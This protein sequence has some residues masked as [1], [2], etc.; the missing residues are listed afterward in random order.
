MTQ[1]K[2]ENDLFEYYLINVFKQLYR[3]ILPTLDFI[4]DKWYFRDN[5]QHDF[6]DLL[7]KKTQYKLAL[8]SEKKFQQKK[9]FIE[10]VNTLESENKLLNKLANVE[11]QFQ[12]TMAR[13]ERD[14]IQL[15]SN[16]TNLTCEYV[17]ECTETYNNFIE[18]ANYFL[19]KSK[20]IEWFNVKQLFN[21]NEFR[22][23][24]E[25]R[26]LNLSRFMKNG[27]KTFYLD[28]D[29]TRNDKDNEKK[30][31]QQ[32][33]L[34]FK[35]LINIPESREMMNTFL[36]RIF[37]ENKF[38]KFVINNRSNNYN[39]RIAYA[40]SYF[41]YFTGLNFYAD[42]VYTYNKITNDL[43]YISFLKKY[44]ANEFRDIDF[45]AY[46]FEDDYD[47]IFIDDLNNDD[48]IELL[49]DNSD[50]WGTENKLL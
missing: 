46:I 44:I 1:N 41:S 20:L 30:L 3:E 12:I 40:T 24:L 32:I 17:D 22:D 11:T 15:I 35:M 18:K 5:I 6:N 29:K 48:N 10:S 43:K 21:K 25:I 38:S 36:Y 16:E 45:I 31:K 37:I 28:F 7:N 4:E 8:A 47:T 39:N 13:N 49:K 23:M 14:K 50:W 33:T 26:F 27:S 42:Y 2:N 9:N 34:L 19:S